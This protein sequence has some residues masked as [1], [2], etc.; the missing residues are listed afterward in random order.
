MANEAARYLRK[1]RTSAER[2]IAWQ[3]REVKHAGFKFRPAVPFGRF[4]V[5]V[6]CLSEGLIVEVDGGTHSADAELRRDA[7][8]ESYL[9]DQGFRVMRFWNADVSENMEGVMD[10]IIAEL[11]TPL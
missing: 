7:A 1:N 9:R 4:V 2:R 5:D 11:E 3:L 6:A 10:T 8:R